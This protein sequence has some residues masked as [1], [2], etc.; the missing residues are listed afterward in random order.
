MHFGDDRDERVRNSPRLRAWQAEC[1]SGKSRGDTRF[2]EQ[3]G[4]FVSPPAKFEVTAGYTGENVQYI[5][6]DIGARPRQS[7]WDLLKQ[8]RL[9]NSPK[10]H[11]H[12]SAWLKPLKLA[13][14]SRFFAMP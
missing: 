4:E 3:S 2:G 5:I 10:T 11:R 9:K 14:C 1:M 8:H 6:G 13:N 12:C 7:A